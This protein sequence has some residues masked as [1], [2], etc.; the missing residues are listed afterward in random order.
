MLISVRGWDRLLCC[1]SIHWH[2]C[3]DQNLTIKTPP[4]L[5]DIEHKK[6][7]KIWI[8][9]S[10][11]LYSLIEARE[12]K[13]ID[14]SGDRSTDKML[15]LFSP[16]TITSLASLLLVICWIVGTECLSGFLF[17]DNKSDKRYVP[18]N[19]EINYKIPTYPHQ[20]RFRPQTELIFSIKN[21]PL[22]VP[23]L[24]CMSITTDIPV[25]SPYGT[26]G[27][28]VELDSFVC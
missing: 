11:N 15:G 14:S 2:H 20:I 7:T 3:Q 4:I 6:F 5:I 25:L 23:A 16:F 24:P 22:L 21:C 13:K 19:G 18:E 28:Q 26:S 27:M 17:E 1:K 9:S 12:R 10:C 8:Q